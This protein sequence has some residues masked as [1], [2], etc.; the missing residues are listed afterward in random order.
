MPESPASVTSGIIPNPQEKSFKLGSETIIG[1]LLLLVGLI[2]IFAATFMV[3]GVLTGRAK[4]P[5]VFNVEAPTFKLPSQNSG[6]E[7]PE[8]A[9]MPA[10]LKLNQNDQVQDLKLIPDEV[11][12]G[13]LN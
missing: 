2:L 3:Y 11:F 7:L 10:G 9:T 5:R 1:Y 12:N 8:G 4:P 13:S 6:V